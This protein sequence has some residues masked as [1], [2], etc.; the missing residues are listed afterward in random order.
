MKIDRETGWIE[1][2]SDAEL[3]RLSDVFLLVA[4]LES[5]V[6]RNI[7]EWLNQTIKAKQLMTQLRA[8]HG[9]NEWGGKP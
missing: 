4:N 6:D 5:E 2:L 7:N 3:Q 8:K 9:Y 1:S